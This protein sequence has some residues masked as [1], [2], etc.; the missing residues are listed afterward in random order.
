MQFGEVAA[1][2]VLFG[3]VERNIQLSLVI[4]QI[5]PLL[6]IGGD[7]SVTCYED[8]YENKY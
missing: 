2:M 5:N 1:D 7:A 4:F 3:F 6:K 8:K